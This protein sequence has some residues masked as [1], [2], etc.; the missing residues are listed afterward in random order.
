MTGGG[1]SGSGGAQSALQRQQRRRRHSQQRR[2][3]E[4]C[5]CS[6]GGTSSSCTCTKN[7][8]FSLRLASCSD[9]ERSLRMLSIS[10]A[11]AKKEER[12]GLSGAAAAA[13]RGEG[14]PCRSHLQQHRRGEGRPV[15]LHVTMQVGTGSMCAHTCLTRQ[16]IALPRCCPTANALLDAPLQLQVALRRAAI[17]RAPFHC[18]DRAPTNENDG[19]LVASRHP[20]QRPHQLLRVSMP[21][22]TCQAGARQ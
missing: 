17:A 18:F 22:A 21:P 11:A 16:R 1:S 3:A 20:E 10:S 5:Q 13:Q 8:V 9:D 15:G 12:A 14:Q 7:S 4:C 6:S 19:R 2:C